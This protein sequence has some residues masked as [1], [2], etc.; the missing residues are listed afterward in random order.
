MPL[1]TQSRK[2]SG[3]SCP[4]QGRSSRPSESGLRSGFRARSPRCST[5]GTVPAR[6]ENTP[7]SEP[8]Q[9][10]PPPGCAPSYI[11]FKLPTSDKSHL[12]VR[13]CW[14]PVLDPLD[15]LDPSVLILRIS[16][17]SKIDR[18][19]NPIKK[20]MVTIYRGG[21]GGGGGETEE[22]RETMDSVSASPC[23]RVPVS[24][25]L[26]A[27]RVPLPASRSSA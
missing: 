3:L 6:S 20:M 21:G 12:L 8:S 4:S 25:S 27:S 17:I 24:S 10:R 18:E 13:G 7:C 19:R 14:D 26:P 11:R 2:G 1:S 9:A 15:P 23:L 16:Y 5:D 22:T